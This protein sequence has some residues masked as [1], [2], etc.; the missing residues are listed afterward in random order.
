MFARW[1]SGIM[2]K[3]YDSRGW[4]TEYKVVADQYD[5]NPTYLLG[6]NT[7]NEQVIMMNKKHEILQ[8]IARLHLDLFC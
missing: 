4:V 8:V 6:R 1:I 7:S 2:T 5:V 3:G